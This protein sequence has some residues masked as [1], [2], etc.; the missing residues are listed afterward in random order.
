MAIASQNGAVVTAQEATIQTA[1]VA[2]SVMTPGERKAQRAVYMRKWYAARSPEQKAAIAA[3]KR[4]YREKHAEDERLRKRMAYRQN[5]PA[6]RTKQRRYYQENCER[7]KQYAQ[8][9]Y[10]ENREDVLKQ[11]RLYKQTHPEVQREAGRRRYAREKNAP[12]VDLSPAQW[13]EIKAAYHFRCAYCGAKAKRLEREHITPITKG[14]A[15]TVSNVVPA[16]RR[17][18]GKKQTGP[19][20]CPIQPLLLTVAEAKTSKKRIAA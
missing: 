7:L 16:C 8:L 5:R 10:Q 11:C 15:H 4:A 20:P 6:I 17:C 19:P 2:I 3:Q 13:E 14:G 1:Q 9:Y 12:I 18:N